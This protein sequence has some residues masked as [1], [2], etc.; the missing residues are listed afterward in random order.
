MSNMSDERVMRRHIGRKGSGA[1]TWLVLG[2]AGKKQVVDA[3]R[4]LIMQR[5]G[6]TARDLRILDPLLSY[7]STIAGRDRAIVISLEHIKAIITAQEVLLLNSRDPFVTPFVDDLHAR[8]LRHHS[9]T[10]TQTQSQDRKKKDKDE[11]KQDSSIKIFPF[12][13]VA[14]E[15]CLEEACSV[16][17]ND[18]KILEQEAH[19]ALDNLTSKISTLNLECVRHVKSR[20]AALT[21]RAQRVRDELENLLDDDEGMAELYLTEK[22]V[23]HHLESCSASSMNDWDD[24]ENR[25]LQPDMNHRIPPEISLERGGDST[26]DDEEDHQN[27]A[28]YSSNQVLASGSNRVGSEIH[29]HETQAG[30]THTALTKNN[31]VEEVEML[32]GA[33]FVQ[34]GG[35]LNKLST[36]KEY[37]DDTEDYINITLDDKQNQI[38]QT[39][40]KVGTASVLVNAFVVVTGVF[41]MNIHIELFDSGMP[42]F[43]GVIFGCTASCIFLYI[44][45]M[46]WYNYKR[47]L[48]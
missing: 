20:L 17:E 3:A 9:A 45:A 7:P 4:H 1:R 15:A 16:L 2:G 28:D 14:L 23:Q 31:N 34:I 12:E 6:L 42:Q 30:T 37:V 48:E 43:L 32:L 19:N 21:A 10:Q 33:Y 38:L 39:G 27:A 36:L 29:D 40:V 44:V 24:M 18:A 22:L 25:V 8:I 5:T 13:F 26:R 47:L 11:T 46:I 41:G 35:T